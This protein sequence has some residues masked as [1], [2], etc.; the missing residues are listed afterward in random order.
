[1]LIFSFSII[2]RLSLGM[3]PLCGCKGHQF[4]LSFH[5]LMNVCTVNRN[6]TSGRDANS[7]PERSWVS[8]AFST[9]NTAPSRDASPQIVLPLN[10]LPFALLSEDWCHPSV[11]RSEHH[12]P[13][14][15]YLEMGSINL[16]ILP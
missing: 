12:Y 2:F 7:L 5:V 3:L 4:Q 10:I 6:V 13:R 11:R 16:W 9:N 15:S 1:M 14:I 8:G